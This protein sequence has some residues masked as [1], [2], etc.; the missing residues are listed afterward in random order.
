MIIIF[1]TDGSINDSELAGYVQQGSNRANSICI[2]YADS[3]R[4]GLSAYLTALRPDGVTITIAA[5]SASFDC[6][7]MRYEGWEVPVTSNFTKYA[8][9]VQ[10]TAVVI[11]GSESV[12]ANYP[13]SVTVN[14]TGAPIA[15]EWDSPITVAQ[16]NDY[17]AQLSGK[18]AV[19]RFSAVGDLPNPGQP[20]AIYLVGSGTYLDAYA[21]V[22]SANAYKRLTGDFSLLV[23]YTGATIDVNLGLHKITAN[24]FNLDANNYISFVSGHPTLTASNSWRY[25][26]TYASSDQAYKQT[27]DLK[28]I[29]N[30]KF[31]LE[32]AE[33]LLNDQGYFQD[34]ELA[35]ASKP[36]ASFIDKYGFAYR[37]IKEDNSNIYFG[38]FQGGVV[39]VSGG[40]SI[41]FGKLLTVSKTAEAD[42]YPFEVS[43]LTLDVYSKNQAKSTFANGISL[44]LDPVTFELTAS[45]D[46]GNG[47]VISVSNGIDLPLESIVVG[48]T[49]YDTYVY[50]GTTYTKVIVMT[51]ATTSV[52]TI[53]PVGDL[54]SGLEKE[55]CV[56]IPVS[57]TSGTF[58][59][60]QMALLALDNASIKIGGY[61]YLH[62]VLANQFIAKSSFVSADGYKTESEYKVVVQN[63][64]NYTLT[65]TTIEFY[66]KSQVDTKVTN[67][68]N[69]MAKMKKDID[70]ALKYPL[71]YGTPTTDTDE[72]VG[73]TT[74]QLP[75]TTLPKGLINYVGGMTQKVNQLAEVD[76]TYS[77]YGL[78]ATP[79]VASNT[80]TISGT[81]T[82][83]SGDTNLYSTYKDKAVKQGHKYLIA[84]NS[85]NWCLYA[86]G[87]ISTNTQRLNIATAS[88]DG[89][90]SFSIRPI[91][92]SYITQGAVINDEF[93]GIFADLTQMFGAGN[94]PTTA[95]DPRIVWLLS[96]L[97]EHPEYDDGSLVSAPVESIVSKGFNIWDE[98]WE[99]GEVNGTTGA[100]ANTGSYIRSKNFIDVQPSTTYYAKS[101][102]TI[103]IYQY[104][105]NGDYIGAIYGK[106]NDTFTTAS[107]CR[108]LLIATASGGTTYNHDI[109]INLSGLMNGTY[110]P[111]QAPSEY[112]I[113][114]EVQAL[115]GYGLG[116]DDTLYNYIDFENKKFVKSL[117]ELDLGD[118]NYS[119]SSSSEL[120]Q[121]SL[122]QIKASTSNLLCSKY[123]YGVLSGG[124][125]DPDK[126]IYVYQKTLFISDS[127]YTDA[128]TFKNAMVG[129]KLVIEIETPAET[130]ISEYIYRDFPNENFIDLYQG[131]EVEFENED[132]M[133]VPYSLTY[134]YKVE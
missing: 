98:E 116:I 80:F 8:G 6:N 110:L 113:P 90:A 89:T 118:L 7:G 81:S 106:T 69:D 123:T 61:T 57:P 124:G 68:Q 86:F 52:P 77:A 46:N 34:E 23:P 32:Q 55:A 104:D 108:K 85:D 127:A 73:L 100:K 5:A 105:G 76:G 41:T 18:A 102:E 30:A 70:Y 126:T 101:T 44:T 125:N 64:G 130:D 15:G 36:N 25:E 87:D 129:Q 9:T 115:D 45:L 74:S 14:A 79:N 59:V 48:A 38:C 21:W 103:T 111:Y 49:Y 2:A 35:Y 16:Y 13:F 3:R 4:D 56:E 20:N 119:Y 28:E 24:S 17:M 11:D 117:I 26:T 33:T 112:P 95:S 51:L 47:E 94:E 58:T 29:A 83:T 54:V 22:E 88:A 122:S 75:A 131:G 91:D 66:D 19:K 37:K 120:F 92:N 97:D 12:I 27:T 82:Y 114:A 132:D 96:Y 40:T 109:C 133:G 93:Q 10:C 50:D 43:E 39:T 128:T 1:N 63:N 53:I 31:V 72:D 121:V 134:Q 65:S 78:T 42:G 62:K 67:I 71:L 107:N 84:S 60:E 99:V